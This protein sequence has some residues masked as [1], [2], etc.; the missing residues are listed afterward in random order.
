MCTLSFWKNHLGIVED[1]LLHQEPARNVWD[2]STAY[3]PGEVTQVSRITNVH[4]EFLEK[5]PG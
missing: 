5:S 2:P 1:D 4:P 3:V